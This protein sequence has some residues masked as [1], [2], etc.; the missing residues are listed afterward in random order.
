MKGTN[1]FVLI[2]TDISYQED[3]VASTT[4]ISIRGDASAA[5][6]DGV[7]YNG[8]AWGTAVG[9]PLVFQLDGRALDLR[10]KVTSSIAS[11][12]LDGAS[13]H[14]GSFIAGANKFKNTEYFTVNSNTTGV[15]ELTLGKF[16]P[17]RYLVS[18]YVP[19]TGQIFKASPTTFEVQGTK[20]V[21][22]S[23]FFY[24][25]QNKDI[26]VIADQNSGNSFDSSDENGNILATN[27]LGAPDG[28][29]NLAP[30][31]GWYMQRPDGLIR[32]VTLN[33]SD[34]FTIYS[35]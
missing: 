13:L 11:A 4:S 10:L 30:G 22:V 26:L 32:E 28:T 34:G 8:T 35:T 12:L 29:G 5:G 18:V 23:D 24:D 16:L 19:E 9:A 31:R 3:Y 2:E 20:L 1:Y 33:N 14:Y 27:H 7:S 25:G 15:V 21:F 17:D 6:S